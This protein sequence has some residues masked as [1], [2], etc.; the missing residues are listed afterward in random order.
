MAPCS[1]GWRRKGKGRERAAAEAGRARWCAVLNDML[2]GLDSRMKAEPF[3]V[4][5]QVRGITR[6]LTAK[7]PALGP[8][9]AH[10]PLHPLSHF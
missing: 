8:L 10:L 6:G 2:R 4:F 5:E 7:G 3:E 1:R 9:W